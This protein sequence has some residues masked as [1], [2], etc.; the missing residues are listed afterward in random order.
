VESFRAVCGYPVCDLHKNWYQKK[1]GMPHPCQRTC[2]CGNYIHDR[3][4]LNPIRSSHRLTLPSGIQKRHRPEPFH[5]ADLPHRR[6]SGRQRT[7]II[8]NG[9]TGTGKGLIARAIHECSPR[10]DRPFIPDQLR[11]HPG[12]FA[13]KRVLRLP[14]GCV[15]GAVS[16]R[17]GKF[18][19]ANAVR[20]SWTRS[21]I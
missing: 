7:T 5:E 21:A 8:L 18:E 11:G 13:R 20:F 3:S 19:L 1:T 16:D 12:G 14:A 9:E 10:R 15:H 6:E 17:P 4:N 2:Q